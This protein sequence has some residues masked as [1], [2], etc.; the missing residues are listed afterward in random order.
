[1]ENFNLNT[2]D[3]QLVKLINSGNKQAIQQLYER[4]ESYWFRMCLRYGRNRQE[5][6]N[7][8]DA[9]IVTP[10]STIQHKLSYQTR[11]DYAQ[12]SYP[13]SIEFNNGELVDDDD[14]NIQI[15]NRQQLRYFRIPLGFEQYFGKNRIKGFISGGFRYNRISGVQ[16][17]YTNITANNQFIDTSPSG[18]FQ[19]IKKQYINIYGGIGLDYQ[20]LNHFH[21]RASVSLHQKLIKK[22]IYSTIKTNDFNVGL[23]YRF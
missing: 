7:I 19:K 3:E 15:E 18:Q 2:N 9:E 1:M 5:D 10:Q 23:Y 8:K 11:T 14:I 22:R 6:I 17:T 16:T 21:T 20:I 4:H 13:I 12:T